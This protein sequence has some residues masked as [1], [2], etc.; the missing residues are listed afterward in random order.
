[1]EH[2]VHY[3][4]S[5]TT[6]SVHGSKFAIAL[7]PHHIITSSVQYVSSLYWLT[8]FLALSIPQ[9]IEQLPEASDSDC[10]QH[11][12]PYIAMTVSRMK[13]VRTICAMTLLLF[14][15]HGTAFRSSGVFNS[16]R[17]NVASSFKHGYRQF[18]PKMSYDNNEEL[19][20]LGEGEEFTRKQ[21]IKEEIEAPFRKVRLF[22][23]TALFAAAAL[24]SIITITKLL[25]TLSGARSEDLQQLYTNLGVNLGGLPVIAL[26]YKRDIDAQRA[27][28]LRIQKGGKLSGLRM[29]MYTEDGPLVVKLSDLRRDRGIDKRVVIVAAPKELLR[30]SLQTSILEAKNLIANDLVIVPLIIELTDGD[31]TLTATS[32]EAMV[33]DEPNIAKFEHIGLA[34]ALASWNDTIKKELE[35][36]IKQ[37]PGALEKGVTIIIKK[38]GKV[39][40]RRFGVPIWEGLVRDV[41]DR[42]D[43]GLDVSNI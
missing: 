42:K 21:L 32:L 17:M 12:L 24:G 28:L 30:T 16:R 34:M 35:V 43:L 8:Q 3:D 37:Q 40:T 6:D 13:K 14:A 4:T 33:P 1:M 2:A 5:H 36:A 39:G 22:L 27:L 19:N 7:K 25:A 10:R 9:Q 20:Q 29:K 38:N 18:A 31:Y 26:L 11:K 41:A 23:Y 15:A